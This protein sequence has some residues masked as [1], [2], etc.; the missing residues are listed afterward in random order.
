MVLGSDQFLDEVHAM[1]DDLEELDEVL[2]KQR[3]AP[4]LPLREIE[5]QLSSRDDAILKIYKTQ[6]YTLKQIGDYFGLHYSRISRIVAKDKTR[7][8]LREV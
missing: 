5:S 7:P 4:A 3:R 8:L 1:I 2:Q 6:H